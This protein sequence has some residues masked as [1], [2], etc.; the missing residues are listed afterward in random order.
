V[1]RTMAIRAGDDLTILFG[2][3]AIGRLSDA[4]LLARFIRREDAVAS[5][6]AFATLV[7]RHGPMVLGVCRRMLGDDHAAA[8]AFQAV[9]LIL[10]RKAPTVRVDDSLGRWLHGVSVRVARR[11]RIMARAERRRFRPLDGLEPADESAP[12]DPRCPDDLRAAIDEEIARLP[13]RY[14]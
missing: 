10:A 12:V 2:V 9:F 7:S 6:A 3:G 13:G 5:E 8:D 11:A 1:A 4:E 14:R